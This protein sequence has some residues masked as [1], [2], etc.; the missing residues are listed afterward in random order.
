MNQKP[1]WINVC[2]DVWRAEWAIIASNV[3]HNRRRSWIYGTMV[4]NEI[5]LIFKACI[6]WPEKCYAKLLEFL[7]E[8]VPATCVLGPLYHTA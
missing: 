8:D 2:A 3:L 6:L 1:L 7:K 4:N 5:V